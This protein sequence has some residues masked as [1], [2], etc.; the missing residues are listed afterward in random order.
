[1]RTS[2]IP[3]MMDSL[4]RNY[5]RSNEYARLFEIGKV[6]LQNEDDNKLP[7]EKNVLTIG[8]Y[9]NAITSI[10]KGCCRKCT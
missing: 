5:S 4:G 8:M 3:S 9:G 1:M 2:T 7:T 10:L 6:Y